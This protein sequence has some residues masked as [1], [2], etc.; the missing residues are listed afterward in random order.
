[1][2]AADEATCRVTTILVAARLPSGPVT[3]VFGHYS[4]EK[5]IARN[6]GLAPLAGANRVTG[7]PIH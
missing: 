1:M 3:R 6:F 4:L 7:A 2:F 5:S